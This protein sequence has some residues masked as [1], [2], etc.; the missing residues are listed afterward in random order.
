MDLNVCFPDYPGIINSFYLFTYLRLIHVLGGKDY[1]KACTYIKDKFLSLNKNTSKQIFTK[2]TCA[3]DT[4]NI[5]V[6]FAAT[7][8]ILIFYNLPEF[9]YIL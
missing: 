4:K 1:Q 2:V 7:R 6:V 5:E 9:F 3:T 8:N